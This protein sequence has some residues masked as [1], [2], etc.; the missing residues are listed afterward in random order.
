V[1]LYIEDG[2]GGSNPLDNTI[3]YILSRFDKPLP[4][5]AAGH[6]YLLFLA[7]KEVKRMIRVIRERVSRLMEDSHGRE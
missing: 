5:E 3:L 6:N 1:E 2:D 4:L 7:D